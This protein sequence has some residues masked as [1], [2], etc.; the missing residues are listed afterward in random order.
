LG[1]LHKQLAPFLYTPATFSKPK[2]L[3]KKLLTK[4]GGSAIICKLS[5]SGRPRETASKKIT[6]KVE[7]T[8]EKPLDKRERM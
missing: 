4:G 1:K 2:K 7:K 8:F 5:T 3:S 6:K